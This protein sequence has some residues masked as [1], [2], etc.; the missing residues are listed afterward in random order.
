MFRIAQVCDVYYI[1]GN[2]NL[3]DLTLQPGMLYRKT[4]TSCE[5]CHFGIN[6]WFSVRCTWYYSYWLYTSKE[7]VLDTHG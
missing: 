2:F 6:N 3:L 1:G 7:L 4:F 5:M